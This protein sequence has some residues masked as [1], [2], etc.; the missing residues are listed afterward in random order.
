MLEDEIRSKIQ[1]R[2]EIERNTAK[3]P[4]TVTH[5]IIIFIS[6]KRYWQF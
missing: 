3:V 2:E 5:M 1:Q 6:W 4:C